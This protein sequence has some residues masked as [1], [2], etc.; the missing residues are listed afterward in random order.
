MG[1]RNDVKWLD[2]SQIE[3]KSDEVLRQKHPRLEI[4]IPIESVVDVGYG[5][6][7]VPI[8]GLQNFDCVGYIDSGLTAIY[9]DEY[10]YSN[11]PTR[12]RFT[13]AH[14][15]SHLILHKAYYTQFRFDTVQQWKAA[16]AEVP[17]ETHTR[18]EYQANMFAGYLLVPTKQLLHHA[19][20]AA[21]TARKH[22]LDPARA[23]V[24]TYMETSLAHTFEVSDSVIARR[25]QTD[26][27]WGA[28]L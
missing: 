24:Q 16:V 21:E 22:K 3:A 6:D 5:I 26:H 27:L 25:M 4:P 20:F 14:E 11:W 9:V 8:P 17:S 12:F 1:D 2:L 13:L 23:D 10:V 28:V 7:I 15:L 18:L 19:R